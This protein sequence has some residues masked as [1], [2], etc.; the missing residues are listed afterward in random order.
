MCR[1]P[2][3]TTMLSNHYQGNSSTPT[4]FLLRALARGTNVLAPQLDVEHALHL[5]ENVLIRGGGA[6]LIGSNSGG[7][8]ANLLAQLRLCHSRLKPLSALFNS[9]ADLLADSLGLDDVVGA[10]DFSETLAFATTTL[11]TALS[12]S[13]LT[14]IDDGDDCF[15]S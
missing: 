2:L 12:V 10:V 7:S 6:S 9:L 1:L 3:S 5:G 4:L 8:L 15:V 13:H 14:T 11:Y